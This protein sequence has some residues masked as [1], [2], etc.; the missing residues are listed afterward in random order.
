VLI[1]LGVPPVPRAN[2]PERAVVQ[3]SLFLVATPLPPSVARHTLPRP[4]NL[5]TTNNYPGLGPSSSPQPTTKPLAQGI[6]HQHQHQHP[7]SSTCSIDCLIQPS[8]TCSPPR[9][10]RSHTPPTPESILPQTTYF[11]SVPRP[12]LRL[13]P[14]PFFS[15]SLTLP[16]GSCF[17]CPAV[18]FPQLQFIRKLSSLIVTLKR[19]PSII[20]LQSLLLSWRSLPLPSINRRSLPGIRPQHRPRPW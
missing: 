5:I 12:R 15:F 20:P 4:L 3:P 11:L 1:I 2:V 10:I 13:P 14:P 19:G 16:P 6:Q 8:A 17:L 7:A 9:Q 18:P